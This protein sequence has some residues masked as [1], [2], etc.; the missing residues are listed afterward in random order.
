[1]TLANF[2]SDIFILCG[3]TYFTYSLWKVDNDPTV[4]IMFMI[5]LVIVISITI[6]Y[7][8]YCCQK[9]NLWNK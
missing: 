4:L 9:G 7:F 1:M 8:V 3:L 2:W 6:V 5:M